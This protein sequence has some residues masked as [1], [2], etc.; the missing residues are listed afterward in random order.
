LEFYMQSLRLFEIKRDSVSM[1]QSYINVGLVYQ[2]K[3]QFNEALKYFEDARTMARRLNNKS[4]MALAENSISLIMVEQGNYEQALRY[5]NHA[6]EIFKELGDKNNVAICYR[7]IGE[8]YLKLG[9]NV[10]SLEN[11]KKSIEL[12]REMELKRE[13]AD[14]YKDLSSVYAAM[15]RFDLAFDNYRMYSERKDSALSEEYLKTIQEMQTKY[16]T[17]QKQKEIQLLNE[18]SAR[19]QAENKR[20]RIMIY[21]FVVGF[22]LILIFSILLFRQYRQIS[23]QRD[24]ISHQKQEITDSIMY[25]SRIQ[26]AIL[27]PKE[28]FAKFLPEHFILFRPRDIVS[29][30]FYWMTNIGKRVYFTAADCTGHGVPGAFMSMLGTAFLNEI[31][32]KN[33]KIN[34]NEILDQLRAHVVSSLHQTGKE[35]ESKDGMDMALCVI[36]IETK[37]LQFSGANNPLFIYR[38][39]ELI[40][41]KADKMPI[42]IYHSK[43]DD[44]SR[45]DYQLEKGDTLYVFSD[46]YVDQFGGPDK[47]KFMKK[48]FKE[49]LLKIQPKPMDEQYL[50]L[51]EAILSWMGEDVEQIDDI[52][53]IGVRI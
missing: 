13:L 24:Q 35:G 53:V 40:E 10:L 32:S 22:M 7:T 11:F 21:S 48:N 26:R 25:A 44:F 12:Y 39:G 18:K 38:K 5:S 49:L 8:C 16:E 28:N 47:R 50:I 2:R 51:N 34:S 46:G 14:L 9:N 41:F 42:G 15:G 30:D 20:Q 43:T 52:L 37:M 45:H 36:D 33:E 3:K 6:L 17:D 27:P 29:G 19:Q 23:E 4:N 1:T 31:V